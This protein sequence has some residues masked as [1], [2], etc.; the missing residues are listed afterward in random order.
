M[1]LGAEE[2]LATCA[3]TVLA[4][5][6]SGP[7]HLVLKGTA[8]SPGLV[9]LRAEPSIS[10]LRIQLSHPGEVT[11]WLGLVPA[12]LREVGLGWHVVGGVGAD[13]VLP[14][15]SGSLQL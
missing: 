7:A 4:A 2:L 3:P 8:L 6:G 12:L 14:A 9:S 1:Q 10:R 13:Q 11:P 15:G 5:A